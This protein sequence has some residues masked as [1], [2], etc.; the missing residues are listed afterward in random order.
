MAMVDSAPS[1][2]GYC[3]TLN[4][5]GERVHKVRVQGNFNGIMFE[6]DDI[7]DCIGCMVMFGLVQGCFAAAQTSEKK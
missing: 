1:V 6:L 2:G 4:Q 5:S 7:A 3:G